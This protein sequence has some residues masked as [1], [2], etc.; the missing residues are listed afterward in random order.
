MNKKDFQLLSSI[1]KEDQK[2]KHY[3]NFKDIQFIWN[4]EWSDPTLIYKGMKFNY[5]E[6][7]DTL[8]DEFQCA[9]NDEYTNE[10]INDED[11][12]KCF[13]QFLI[14]NEEQCL[15]I[16]DELYYCRKNFK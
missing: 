14:D 11:D 8:Y 4:G 12:E 5:Y 13:S 16:I 15:A 3:R 2:I 6:I 1:F 10:F 7:E 9:I